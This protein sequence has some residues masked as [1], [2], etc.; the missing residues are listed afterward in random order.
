MSLQPWLTGLRLRHKSLRVLSSSAAR[1]RCVE[2]WTE[3]ELAGRPASDSATSVTSAAT[4]IGQITRAR[5]LGTLDAFP[6]KWN[7]SVCFVISRWLR[8]RLRSIIFATTSFD[9]KRQTLQMSPIYFWASSY[10][11]RDIKLSIF[12][13]QKVC[14]GHEMQFS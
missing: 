2:S 3:G 5:F 7:S 12:Y 11:F 8:S 14:Q 6:F 13:I 1:G 10:R 4:R 9:C